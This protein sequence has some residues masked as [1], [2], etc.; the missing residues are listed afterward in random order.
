MK[1]ICIAFFTIFLFLNISYSQIPQTVSW[2]GV[3]ED[4]EGNNLSGSHNITVKLYEQASGGTQVWSEQHQN[5]EVDN[6]LVNLILGSVTPLAISFE[7]QYWLELTVDNSTPLPRIKLNSVPYSLYSAKASGIIVNDSI[8][9]KD[10]L[11]IT[12]MVI[13]PN[14]GTFKMMNNDSVFYSISVNSPPVTSWA[15]PPNGSIIYDG[16]TQSIYNSQGVIIS[17][18]ETVLGS[19][20]NE[21]IILKKYNSENPGE[22]MEQNESCTYRASDGAITNSNHHYCYKE[23][24]EIS[25]KDT[26]RTYN[27]S[28]EIT[29]TEEHTAQYIDGQIVREDKITEEGFNISRSNIKTYDASGN[30]IKEYNETENKNTSSQTISNKFY[31][32]GQT[33]ENLKQLYQDPQSTI[34]TEEF[35]YKN[36]VLSKIITENRDNTKIEELFDENGNLISKVITN[37]DGSHT[38]L[39]GPEFIM[40]FTTKQGASGTSFGPYFETPGAQ[41]LE[42]GQTSYGSGMLVGYKAGD[43]PGSGIEFWSNSIIINP[44]SSGTAYITSNTEI[45]GNT[46]TQGSAYVSGNSTT[47]G[48]HQINGNLN[49]GGTKNFRIDHPDDPENKYLVHAAVESD[50]V[51]N[52]YIGNVITDNQGIAVVYLPDYVQKV[53]KNFHYQLTVIGDFAQAIISKKI[54]NNQFE[55]RTDKPNI[56]V[57]WEITA[58]RNDKFLQEHPFSPIQVKDSENRK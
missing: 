21:H 43:T 1:R 38:A 10:S 48:N 36:N 20:G 29:K 52:K 46:T 30:L 3:I 31:K 12:R 6:G 27:N 4:N 18:T 57:S 22:I 2:Q 49:V 58:E 34:R 16:N 25:H 15:M 56:E 40:G 35:V 23:G 50:K 37:P 54:Y 26:K 17:S 11:G 8:V 32:N 53:N 19:D 41:N 5:I 14:S 55:I 51:L 33:E 42:I 13:N 39:R 7:K 45:D 44:S 9:L 28:S 24:V 47:N